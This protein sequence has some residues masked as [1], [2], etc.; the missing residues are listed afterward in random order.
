MV[1]KRGP[2]RMERL[3]DVRIDFKDE[4]KPQLFDFWIESSTGR[5]GVLVSG[6]VGLS[7]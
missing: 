1:L 6:E 7:M 3:L 5:S 2:R 4:Q